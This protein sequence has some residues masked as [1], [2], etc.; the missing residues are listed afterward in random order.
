MP[1]RKSSYRKKTYK[2]TYKKRQPYQVHGAKLVEA[3]GAMAITK[4]KS[5]LG[6]N[7]ETHWFDTVETNVSV[8]STCL[9]MANPLII[10]VDDTVNGRT[11]NQVRAISYQVK[12]R[13][14][15]NTAATAGCLVR[16]IFVKFN[17]VR[18][19]VTAL[20]GTDFLDAPTRITSK[21]NMGDT[22]DAMGYVVLYDK[23]FKVSVSGQDNDTVPFSFNYSPT[24]WHLKWT[25]GD[26]TGL[27]SN[28]QSDSVR[29]F[30]YTSEPGANTPN[31]WADHRIRFVDN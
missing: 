29:G 6:L 17:D 5:K 16:L 12:G 11:G 18:G 21:Y 3:L 4:L 15:A 28:F 7:T 19:R 24:A 26:T 2:K 25:A 30:I 31:Y 20:D 1:Y 8:T 10:P 27:Q 13:I 22:A 9:S 23:T 14:Q